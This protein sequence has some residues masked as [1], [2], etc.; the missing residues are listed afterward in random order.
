MIRH[1]DS[2]NTDLRKKIKQGE[3]YLGGNR[4][5]KIYG[6]LSCTSGKRMKRKN[7]VFF[8]TEKEAI[9]KGYRPCG[10]CMKSAYL[11]WKNGFI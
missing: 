10:N 3:I 4:N 2:S 9:A 6:K 8:S 7:R 1:I 11:K 5:L